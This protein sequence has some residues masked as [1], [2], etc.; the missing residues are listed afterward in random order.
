MACIAGCRCDARPGHRARYANR[1]SNRSVSIGH[2][3]R[4]SVRSGFTV[5]ELLVATAVAGIATA[6]MTVTVV[7]Q[8]RFYSSAAQVMDVRSQLRDAADILASDIRGAA[9][10]G[11]GLPFMSDTAIEMFTTVGTSVACSLPAPNAI[12]LPPASLVSG[13]AACTA[14]HRRHRARLRHSVGRRGFRPMGNV[15]G[16]VV[17]LAAAFV[18]MSSIERIHHRCR[19]LRRRERIPAHAHSDC[20]ISRSQRRTDSI[21]AAS[22]IQLLQI[23]RRRMVSRIPPV[24]RDRYICVWC[25]PAGERTVSSISP[26]RH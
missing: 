23:V 2:S 6:L 22:A 1:I 14:G 25:H 12:G 19:L 13:S 16:R 15:P 26:R 24:Q 10:A 21:P 5:A 3:M 4:L 8:Q 9:I 20:F 11:F 17:W 7:R 18:D